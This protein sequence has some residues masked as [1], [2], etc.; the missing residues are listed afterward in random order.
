MLHDQLKKALCA[1]SPHECIAGKHLLEM[2]THSSYL[3]G[4]KFSRPRIFQREHFCLS[5]DWARVYH[6]ETPYPRTGKKHD[7]VYVFEDK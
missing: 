3:F 5:I 6:D 4:M 1:M 2:A 7:I